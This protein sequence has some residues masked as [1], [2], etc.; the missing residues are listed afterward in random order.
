MDELRTRKYRR[1][2]DA[3]DVDGD[4]AITRQ[5]VVM[6]SERYVR[7]RGIAADSPQAQRMY[8]TM[9]GFWESVIAP[10]DA[11]KDG[12]VTSAELTRAFAATFTDRARYPEEL[13]PIADRFFDLADGDGDDSLSRTE[14]TH[15]FGSTGRA[16]DAECAEV[17]DAL[18]LD[19]SGALS[20]SEYHRAVSE[21]FY[22]NAP[23]SPANHMFGRLV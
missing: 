11:D 17:F 16:T 9:N 5:D 19:S 14:F 10:A 2:F 7:A 6:M 13:A 20:R 21:F 4:S 1:W 15:I 18:D 12:R 3:A 8:D 22:G 23:D